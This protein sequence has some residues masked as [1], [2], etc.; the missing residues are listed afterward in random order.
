MQ[1]WDGWITGLEA[2]ADFS[3]ICWVE[4]FYLEALRNGAT[5]CIGGGGN[6]HPELIYAVQ[7]HFLAGRQA[8]AEKAQADL[9][10]TR[11]IFGRLSHAM[12][13]IQ[14]MVRRGAAL[15]PRVRTGG[16]PYR[17]QFARSGPYPPEVMDPLAAQLDALLRPYRKVY[18]IA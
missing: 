11:K 2:Q 18:G 12:S 3:L 6:T 4:Y 5:G 8:E 7:D 9:N 10:R 15:E 1:R 17:E 14:Y 13:G 16:G